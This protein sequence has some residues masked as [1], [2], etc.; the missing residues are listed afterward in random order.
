MSIFGHRSKYTWKKKNSI[1][2]EC[3]TCGN[4]KI[5]KLTRIRKSFWECNVCGTTFDSETGMTYEKKKY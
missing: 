2:V 3:P 4:I 1:S 5:L